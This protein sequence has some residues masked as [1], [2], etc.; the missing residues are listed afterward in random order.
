M[1]SPFQ[2]SLDDLRADDLLVLKTVSEGWFVEYKQQVPTPK[3]IAKSVSAFAN[4]EGGWLFIGIKESDDGQRTGSVFP[5]VAADTIGD[6]I[7][8]IRDAV[9][10]HTS[11]LPHFEV[12]ALL[13]PSA[14]G[15]LADGS[16]VLV[17]RVP[18]G[19]DTP[20]LHSSGRIYRRKV[21]SSDPEH[22][23]DRAVLDLLVERS[24][25]AR[26]RLSRFLTSDH[27]VSKAEETSAYA[28]LF[29]TQDPLNDSG[30][31]AELS[32]SDF[33]AIAAAKDIWPIDTTFENAFTMAKGYVA[34]H[35]GNNDRQLRL[36]TWEFYLAG[37]SVFTL[38][39]NVGDPR[40]NSGYEHARTFA[41]RLEPIELGRIIDSN[42]L[43]LNLA[44]CLGKHFA[45]LKAGGIQRSTLGKV[46]LLNVWRKTPFFDSQGYLRHTEKYGL[47]VC[48][49]DSTFAPPTTELETFLEIETR[50]TSTKDDQAWANAL[51][52]G[53]PLWGWIMSALGVPREAILEMREDV[54]M[55][56]VRTGMITFSG[57]SSSTTSPP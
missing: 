32:F 20:Y 35:V 18:P 10:A 21:D 3:D 5:G 4:H 2:R 8:R 43:M 22:E 37:T 15:D 50:D 54:V 25:R 6:T 16:A 23:T 55:G 34:R 24:R 41:E 9:K 1:Y 40:R 38:P 36:F 14:T 56:A 7:N 17:V 57:P 47:P 49:Y 26:R 12:R 44:V 29:L 51:L 39:L 30:D 45:A 31:I 13:G 27:V 19:K 33:A 46:K 48:Q 42:A 52:M 28:V 53:V 11:P